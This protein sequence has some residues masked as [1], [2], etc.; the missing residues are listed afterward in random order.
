MEPR[1]H[2][3]RTSDGVSIAYSVLGEGEP[4]VHMSLLPL[5]HLQGEWEIPEQRR[6]YERLAQTRTVIRYD[7]RGTGLSERRLT[8]LSLD[9]RMLDLE[10]VVKRLNLGRFAI[11]APLHAGPL[12]V[13]YAARNPERVS[14]LILWCT[15]AS[16]SAWARSPLV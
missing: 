2:Y 7:A 1:I 5:S 15:Y 9:A 12:A 8:D 4:L 10:V 11:F 3:V 14:H 6:W 13:A 16:G